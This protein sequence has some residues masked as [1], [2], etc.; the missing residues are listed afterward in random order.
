MPYGSPRRFAT[1]FGLA[2]TA[3]RDDGLTSASLP[4]N[5]AVIALYIHSSFSKGSL[6]CRSERTPFTIERKHHE[7]RTPASS[8]ELRTNAG[9]HRA[10]GPRS[11]RRQQGYRRPGRRAYRASHTRTWHWRWFVG[12]SGD[13]L[14]FGPDPIHAGLRPDAPSKETAMSRAAAVDHARAARTPRP[15]LS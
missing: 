8:W 5:N 12:D 10:P 14:V 7:G 15:T 2:M 6:A 1:A 13:S 3:P 9:N 11:N 4:L